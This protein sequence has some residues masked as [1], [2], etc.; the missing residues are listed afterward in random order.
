MYRHLN[1]TYYSGLA[2]INR[3]MIKNNLNKDNTDLLFSDGKQRQSL[4]NKRTGAVLAAKTLL[5]KFGG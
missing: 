3:F 1:V 2:D 4:N 5:E